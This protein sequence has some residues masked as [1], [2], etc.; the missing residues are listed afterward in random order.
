MAHE[1]VIRSRMRT[2]LTSRPKCGSNAIALD[3]AS[4]ILY[5]TR[6]IGACR[7]VGDSAVMT[8]QPDRFTELSSLPNVRF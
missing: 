7:L 2:S 1:V 4:A 6:R 8:A 3:R 5:G